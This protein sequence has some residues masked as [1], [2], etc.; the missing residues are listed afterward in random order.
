MVEDGAVSHKKPMLKKII[1][2]V[3]NLDVHPN[4]ITV[5]RVKAILLNGWILPTGGASAMEGVQSM[6]LP[7]TS[8]FSSG[9]L[10]L[11]PR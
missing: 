3:L 2:K 4:R 10:F 5:S 6:W 9:K 11:S 7:R 8:S 1:F